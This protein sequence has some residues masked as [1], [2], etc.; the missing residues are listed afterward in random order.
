MWK[1]YD[2]NVYTTVM[3]YRNVHVMLK[4]YESNVYLYENRVQIIL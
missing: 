1:Q 2:C 4:Q 3:Y